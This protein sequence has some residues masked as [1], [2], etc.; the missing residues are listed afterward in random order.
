MHLSGMFALGAMPV[1]LASDAWR[2]P[3]GAGV[4]VAMTLTASRSHFGYLRLRAR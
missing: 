3:T 4:M 1:L 2:T